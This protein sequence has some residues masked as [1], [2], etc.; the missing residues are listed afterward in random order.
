MRPLP[1]G[2]EARLDVV[3]TAAMTVRF[4]ELGPVHPVY[5]TYEMARH[6]EE[7]GRKLL[8]AHLDH[9]EAAVGSAVAVEHR[10]PAR[11]GTAVRV[12]ARCAAVRGN[13]VR[14]ACTATDGDGR[15]LGEGSTEQVVLSTDALARLTG[16]DP[17]G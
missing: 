11:V 10:A 9:G 13:R 2:A 5:A 14:C 16:V 1:V 12:V 7:A 4:A 8:L 15:L 6:F 3:V 17:C